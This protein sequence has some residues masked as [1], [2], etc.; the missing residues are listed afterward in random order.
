MGTSI[1]ILTCQT[2]QQDHPHACGDKPLFPVILVNIWGSSPRVWGQDLVRYLMKKKIRIIPTRVG[3]S[4][5]GQS[6]I[7]W[8]QDHP[9]ACGDKYYSHGWQ[10]Y[11][12]G[13]SP[14]V[15]GQAATVS[16][17]VRTCGIIPT[18]VGTR[19]LRLYRSAQVWDHPHACGDKRRTRK[20][21][22][23]SPGSSPRVWGQERLI[24][25]I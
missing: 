11:N 18:R 1:Y 13:S 8:T 25:C 14:R 5:H 24:L 4:Q 20:K 17:I 21:P 2:E 9:H 16:H 15:W 22:K 7:S 19:G 6:R 10:V 12:V 23:K 3:T